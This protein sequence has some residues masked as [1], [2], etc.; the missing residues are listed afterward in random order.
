MAKKTLLDTQIP[1]TQGQNHIKL[2]P[3]NS[4]HPVLS[5]RHLNHYY[6]ANELRKQ[7]LFDINLD[8]Y[9][10]EI[11]HDRTF[12]LWKRN[13]ADVDG[14]T[15]ATVRGLKILGEMRGASKRQLMQVRRQI[16]YIFQ[17]HNLLTFLSA[18]PMWLWN[19][20]MNL[21]NTDGLVTDILNAVGLG[22]RI[23]CYRQSFRVAI[24]RA[25]LV[26]PKSSLQM[27]LLLPL[28]KNLVVTS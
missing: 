15:F 23:G 6:G 3:Q 11:D 13:V 19:C 21:Q 1:T 7:T 25:L 8:I 26:I 9:S 27:N 5:A 10:G 14:L 18:R 2:T 28:I 20:M 12:W 22:E 4:S 17:A 16:G 24:A